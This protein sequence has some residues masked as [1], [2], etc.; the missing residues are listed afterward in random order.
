MRTPRMH[1][2]ERLLAEPVEPEPTIEIGEPELVDE[3]WEP[4]EPEIIAPEPE[5]P[6]TER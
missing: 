2:V 5:A 1:K 3:H 6:I 4:V